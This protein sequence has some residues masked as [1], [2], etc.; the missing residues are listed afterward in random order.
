[1]ELRKAG[2]VVLFKFPNTDRSV[3]KLRPALL[4]AKLPGNYDDWLICMISSQ[5]HQCIEGFDEIIRENSPDFVRSGLK[6]DSVI[7]ITRIAVVSGDILLGSIG[8]FSPELLKRIRSRL[9]D[10]IKNTE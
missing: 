3:S 9:A 10:W 7:R 6:T 2:Q 5:I 4:L 8:E 1:M